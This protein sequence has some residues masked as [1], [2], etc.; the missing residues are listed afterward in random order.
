[1]TQVL[2]V[3]AV[4]L[5]VATEWWKIWCRSRQPNDARLDFLEDYALQVAAVP[6]MTPE[7]AAQGGRTLWLEIHGGAN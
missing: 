7:L 2:L 1:V 3:I 5:L 6:G 4:G